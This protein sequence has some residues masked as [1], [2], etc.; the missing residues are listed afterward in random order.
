MMRGVYINPKFEIRNPKQA[1]LKIGYWS[2]S[3]PINGIGVRAWPA[4]PACPAIAFQ[5][6]RKLSSEGRCLEFGVS[7]RASGRILSKPGPNPVSRWCKPG[8]YPGLTG[9][10]RL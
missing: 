7:L 4:G 8:F 6:R 3:V 2:F 10:A 1:L 9:S 5:R